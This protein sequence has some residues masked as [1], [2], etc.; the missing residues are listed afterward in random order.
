L[1]D[2][3]CNIAIEVDSNHDAGEYLVTVDEQYICSNAESDEK[4]FIEVHGCEP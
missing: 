4:G 1:Q 2:I 3:W